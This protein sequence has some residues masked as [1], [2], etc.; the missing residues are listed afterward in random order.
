MAILTDDVND[1]AGETFGN[2]PRPRFNFGNDHADNGP[3][4]RIFGSYDACRGG[5]DRLAGR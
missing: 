2:V 4:T 1:D 3:R 5:M